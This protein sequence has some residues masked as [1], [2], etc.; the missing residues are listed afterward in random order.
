MC[1]KKGKRKIILYSVHFWVIADGTANMVSYR[2]EKAN[3]CLPPL[4]IQ[5]PQAN[6]SSPTMEATHW[7][8][9]ITLKQVSSIPEASYHAW[10]YWEPSRGLK[11]PGEVCYHDLGPDIDHLRKQPMQSQSIFG[12][13]CCLYRVVNGWQFTLKFWSTFSPISYWH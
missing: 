2:R 10:C 1:F 3:P 5:G 9:R 4:A 13:K 6:F 11:G 7:R 8:S 12:P